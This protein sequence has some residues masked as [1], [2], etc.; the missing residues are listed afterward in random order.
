MSI[1][2]N[3]LFTVP[4]I[5]YLFARVLETGSWK[6]SLIVYSERTLN[7]IYKNMFSCCGTLSCTGATKPRQ[8]MDERKYNKKHG[9]LFYNATPQRSL[10]LPVSGG[11]KCVCVCVLTASFITAQ[12][13]SQSHRYIHFAR[14]RANLLPQMSSAAFPWRTLSQVLF[15]LIAVPFHD[16]AKYSITGRSVGRYGR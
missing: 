13:S 3:L 10:L 12:P 11:P 7:L 8:D 2:Q 4:Q 5:E 16:A 9:P 15:I 6:H 14:L 1:F